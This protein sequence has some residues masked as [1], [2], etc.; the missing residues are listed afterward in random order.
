MI[1]PTL[2]FINFLYFDWFVDSKC[3]RKT[4]MGFKVYEFRSEHTKLQSLLASSGD[5]LL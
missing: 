3:D 2:P 1:L 4:E 5:D